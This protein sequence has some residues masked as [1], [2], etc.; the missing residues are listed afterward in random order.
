MSLF[1]RFL[2]SSNP[3]L[4][5]F[6]RLFCFIAGRRRRW[7]RY[8]RLWQKWRYEQWTCHICPKWSTTSLLGHVSSTT[9]LDWSKFFIVKRRTNKKRVSINIWR[10][11]KNS[12]QP[13]W[14]E[15]LH[16]VVDITVNK[17]NQKCETNNLMR[18]QQIVTV[19]QQLCKT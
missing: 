8:L 13:N 16:N 11:A 10:E 1:C 4:Q 5:F 19:K 3:H 7:W 6:R 17:V 2:R 15:T 12:L 9:K 18:S 14:D